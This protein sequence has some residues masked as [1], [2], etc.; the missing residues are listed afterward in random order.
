MDQIPAQYNITEVSSY[1]SNLLLHFRNNTLPDLFRKA[2]N[3]NRV[4]IFHKMS[5]KLIE[6]LMKE[7][8]T[9]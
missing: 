7:E 6:R 3:N 8:L 5:D 4:R 9:E 2:V 1:I